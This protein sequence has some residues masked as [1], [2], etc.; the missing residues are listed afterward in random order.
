MQ[1][2]YFV[3]LIAVVTV[4]YLVVG[5]IGNKAVDKTENAMRARRVQRQNERAVPTQPTRRLADQLTPRAPGQA[6]HATVFPGAQAAAPLQGTQQTAPVP[7]T[8]PAARPLTEQKARF[9]AECGAAL[10][11]N[12]KFCPMCGAVVESYRGRE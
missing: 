3:G 8:Q 12:A 4:I 2:Y 11:E 7:R 6:P 5:W 10:A 9:C 1:W